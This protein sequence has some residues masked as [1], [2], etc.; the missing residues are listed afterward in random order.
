MFI[1]LATVFTTPAVAL[2]LTAMLLIVIG[3]VLVA[4]YH[5]TLRKLRQAAER[6]AAG[7]LSRKV[8]IRGFLPLGDL[9]KSLNRMAEQIQDRY[10]SE[11]RQ[12]LQM[13]AVLSSWTAQLRLKFRDGSC[14]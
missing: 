1:H 2:L 4:L 13:E 9:A 7:D 12:R 5:H 14:R 8:E 11:V 3:M 10:Q 6:F